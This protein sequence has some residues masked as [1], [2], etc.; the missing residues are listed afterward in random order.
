MR[1]L[2]L[3]AFFI[4]G[5]CALVYEVIWTRLLGLVMGNTVYAVSTTLAAFM[6]GLAL[7]SFFIGR[8]ADRLERPGRFYGLLEVLIG[9]YCLGLPIF[10]GAADPLYTFAYRKISSSF[11]VL[12]AIRFVTAGSILLIPAVMMGATLPVLSRFYASRTEKLGWEVGRLYA[13]NTW[14]AVSGTLLAGFVLLPSFGVKIS[15]ACAA[16]TNATLG[17]AV[18]L[19][20]RSEPRR[21]VSAKEQPEGVEAR[22]E[23]G[24]TGNEGPFATIAV[25][26][27]LSGLAALVYEVAWTR[28]VALLIGPSTY[29]FA[30]MLSCF[31]VGLALGSALAARWID[32]WRAN[33]TGLMAFALAGAAIGALALLPALSGVV[34]Y[35]REMTRQHS[36]SFYALYAAYFGLL[37]LLLLLPTTILGAVFPVAV[38]AGLGGMADVGRKV[39]QLYA[40]NTVGAIAG[41]VIGGFVLIPALGLARAVAVGVAIHLLAASVLF[42]RRRNV[43]PAAACVAVGALALVLSPHLDSK[44]LSS[45][46]Y[47]YLYSNE[48]DAERVLQERE[49]LYY[50][51]GVTAT[52]A[53][54]K[55]GGQLALSIDGKVDASLGADMDTQI[56][57][58]HLPLLASPDPRSVL[59]VGLASGVTLGSVETHPDVEK[60]D[61]VEIS[62]EVIEACSYF[63]AYNNDPL[64]DPRVNLEVHDARNFLKMTDRTYDVIISEPSNPWMSGAS[65]LFTSEFFESCSARL[66]AGGILCQWLQAY[67]IPTPML[68]SV[69]ATFCGAFEHVALWMPLTGDLILLGSDAPLVF[70]P[71]LMTAKMSAE[72]PRRDLE[73]IHL[74]SWEEL[75]GMSVGSGRDLCGAVAGAPIQTDSRPL[76]EFAL[77]R[78][79]HM[80][81]ELAAGNLDW[82]STPLGD[83]AA[84]VAGGDDVRSRARLSAASY[85]EYLRGQ[86]CEWSR[87]AQGAL[88]HYV[89]ALDGPAGRRSAKRPAYL[90]M[91]HRGLDLEREGRPE[92]ADRM[93]RAAAGLDPGRSEAHYLLGLRL[94]E[95]GRLKEAAAEL[96]A[97]VAARPERVEPALA[98]MD[99]LSQ[100]GRHD[101]AESIAQRML[102]VASGDPRAWYGVARMYARSGNVGAARDAL[103]RALSLGGQSMR[104]AVASDSVLVSAGVTPSGL[105][106]PDQSR[107][108]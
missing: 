11:A 30:L 102:S 56:L 91:C 76:L 83:V 5:A 55:T 88:T 66:N 82:L 13:L 73:R 34:P 25:A 16:V 39:G 80:R 24:R 85:K 57:L 58:A 61:C 107:G 1:V 64:S 106:T 81:V 31:L 67:A 84:L 21:A 99:V 43:L 53:V 44:K 6:A 7:G 78:T 65:A 23:Q 50:K 72:G 2:I 19:A 69:V 27:A 9:L 28:I 63:D 108:R 68:K 37:A 35:V 10:I 104:N 94:A 14:G 40:A 89:S 103:A 47:K 93:Y 105:T 46:P 51:E 36:Q 41:S 101:Q 29:A 62:P 18:L 79:L 8:T 87:D 26:F 15:L 20:T 100:L 70:D 77:P 32:R 42:L 12:T 96:Q 22:R 90:M 33:A 71:D 92:E 86:V 52:V 59:V 97:A 48:A 38:R 98:L 60:I 75:I 74:A 54:T 49:V 45:G 4:S 95:T 17:V 3:I